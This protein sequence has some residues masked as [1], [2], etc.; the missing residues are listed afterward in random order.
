[1][2]YPSDLRDKEWELIKHHFS[3]GNYGNRSKYDKRAL[4]NAVFYVIKTGCQWRMLPKDLP[5]YSTVHSFYRRC[6]IKGVWEKLMRELV[7]K[8]RSIQGR[9]PNPSYSLI[10][11]RSVKTTSASEKRGIDGGKKCKGT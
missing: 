10:D 4:V 2:S 3:C 5:P 9:N 6:R 8:S 11:S 7:G 1:M